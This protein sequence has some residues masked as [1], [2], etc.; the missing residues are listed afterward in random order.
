MQML[1]QNCR[2][3][4]S[5]GGGAQHWPSAIYGQNWS[6]VFLLTPFYAESMVQEA[7]TKPFLQNWKLIFPAHATAEHKMGSMS[8]RLLKWKETHNAAYAADISSFQANLL[9]CTL[10][11][12]CNMLCSM[13]ISIPKHP[14]KSSAPPA[15]PTAILQLGRVACTLCWALWHGLTGVSGISNCTTGTRQMGMIMWKTV[16]I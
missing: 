6:C 8:I 1:L 13:Q 10:N 9:I 2:N 12:F 3:C 15:I 14:K 5:W 16:F 11:A 4:S 7:S